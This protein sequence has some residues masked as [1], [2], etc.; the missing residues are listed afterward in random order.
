MPWLLAKI[1]SDLLAAGNIVFAKWM[2]G[3]VKDQNLYLFSVALVSLPFAGFGI[4]D[5]SQ[6][7]SVADA[8][9][10]LLVGITYIGSGWFYYRALSADKALRTSIIQRLG[11]L[12]VHAFSVALLHETLDVSQ[13]VGF[14]L[15]MLAGL[16]LVWASATPTKAADVANHGKALIKSSNDT[17]NITATVGG[18]DALGTGDAA[19]V[20]AAEGKE[21]PRRSRRSLNVR[22]LLDTRVI[23]SVVSVALGAIS[24]VLTLYLLRRYTLDVTYNMT[25]PGVVLG[26]ILILGA[27]GTFNA[28][29]SLFSLRPV[30]SSA[31]VLEQIVRLISLWFA[32]LAVE[33][34]DSATLPSVLSGLVPVYVWVIVGIINRFSSSDGSG[35]QR[36]AAQLVSLALL[37]AGSYLMSK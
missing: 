21:A 13:Q 27:S 2:L 33:L 31:L 18:A 28:A 20:V 7:T 10:A 11:P 3:S 14:W 25:R 36:R 17:T 24:T 4:Y 32:N 12:F 22:W 16:L 8:G 6:V 1:F 26:T 5:L 35:T 15:S 29:K 9:I 37:A 23:L 19:D 34:A 30:K